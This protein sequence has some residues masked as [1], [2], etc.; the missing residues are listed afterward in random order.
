MMNFIFSIILIGQLF[1]QEDFMSG[2][3]T[4]LHKIS[5]FKELFGHVHR[6]PSRYSNSLSTLSCG[7]PIKVFEWSVQGAKEKSL[8]VNGDWLY[9]QVG[10]YKGYMLKESLSDKRPTCFQD[11]F[12]RFFDNVGLSLTEMYYWGK[13]NDHFLTGRSKVK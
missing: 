1:A 9:V 3:V 6:N 7:H 13:L 11:E 2:K 4:K 5:Y 10:P 8:E 12:P